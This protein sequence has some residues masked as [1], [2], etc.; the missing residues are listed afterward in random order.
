MI[1][2]SNVVLRFHYGHRGSQNP[3]VSKTMGRIAV[4]NYAYE[5]PMPQP[6]TFWLCKVDRNIDFSTSK[7]C[8]VVTPIYQVPND[9][10]MRL[11]PGAFDK[12]VVG[13]HVVC[14]PKIPN[15]YWI[16]PFS[17]KRSFI[18]EQA[19]VRYQSV[20]VPVTIEPGHAIAQPVPVAALP[21]EASS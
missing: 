1:E 9:K 21:P 11:I 5:G 18:K 12:E 2:G 20:V 8:F 16:A 4:I 13:R 15:L 10:V 19:Q 7:G 17:I 3:I 6:E 14:K